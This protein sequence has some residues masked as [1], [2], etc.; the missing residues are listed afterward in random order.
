MPSD[1]C[2]RVTEMYSSQALNSKQ[3]LKSEVIIFDHVQVKS[4]DTKSPFVKPALGLPA[5]L[6]NVG[7]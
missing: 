4:R 1:W 7:K 6:P 2:I 3:H 5:L